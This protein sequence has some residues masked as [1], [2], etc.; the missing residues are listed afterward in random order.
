MGAS[1]ANHDFTYVD[2]FVACR[3]IAKLGI[4]ERMIHTV[5]GMAE[6]RNRN[7]ETEGSDIQRDL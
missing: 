2:E 5:Y 3:N 6:R 1:I 4:F 7:P